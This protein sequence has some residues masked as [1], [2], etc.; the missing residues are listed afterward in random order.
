MQMTIVRLQIRAFTLLESLL[1]LLVTSF[2][3]LALSGSVQ[4]SFEKVENQLFFLEF[5]NFYRESQKLSISSEEKLDL[6]ITEDKISNG[7]RTLSLPPTIHA[8]SYQVLHF[9]KTGGNSS[10]GKIVFSTKE[11][12]VTYQL[13]IGN[14]KIKKTSR[15]S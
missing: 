2:I 8:P 12:E 10:L 14:G 9:D 7:Y 4:A 6:T 15:P 5:E 13:Y 1:T 3:L 11:E